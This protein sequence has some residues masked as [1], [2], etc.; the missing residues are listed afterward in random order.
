MYYDS[1][2]KVVNKAK[3]QQ[4]PFHVLGSSKLPIFMSGFAGC[5][6]ITLIIKLQ[7]ISDLSKFLTV[8]AGIM[9]PFFSVMGAA[10]SSEL[11]DSIVDSRILGFLVMILVGMW[12]WGRE[13][14]RE[15]TYEGYHT[16]NVMLGLAVG[17]LLFILSEAMLFFPFFW[18]FFHVSLSPAVTIGGV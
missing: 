18:A 11:P 4:H 2:L 9:E 12:S 5:L 6:A 8:G 15:S 13:L 14:V 3:N 7:N 16:S 1:R 17:M 10:P